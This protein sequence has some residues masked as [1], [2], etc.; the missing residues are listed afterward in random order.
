MSKNNP[1]THARKLLV[2]DCYEHTL[3]VARSLARA[4]YEVILGVTADDLDR[5]YAHLSRSISSTWLHPDIVSDADGFDVVFLK[6]LNQH[7][8][9]KTVFPVGENSVRKLAAIRPSIPHETLIVMPSNDAIDACMN[10]SRAYQLADEC[11]IPVPGTRTVR[12]AEKMLE[13]IDELGMPAIAKP[14]DST[15]LLLN[16]KCVFVRTQSDLRALQENWPGNEHEYVVQNEIAGIRHNCDVVAENGEIKT[17]FEAEVLRTDQ[18]DYA[19]NSVFDRSI[20]PISEHREYCERLISALNYTGLALIQFLRDPETGKTFFLEANPRAGAA[21]ALAVSCGVDLP[22][23]ALRA[24][25]GNSPDVESKYLLYRAR[26]SFHDDLLGIRKA[27][28]YRDIGNWKTL[29]WLCRAVVDATRANYYST[30]VWSDPKPTVKIFW[31]LLV[32]LIFRD[33][34]GLVAKQNEGSQ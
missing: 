31:D 25:A 8:D 19:G 2:L 27:R 30:F 4:G 26:S 22:V 32:R 6:F 33:K 3:T 12:S 18:L 15:N 11:G 34:R 7:P 23:G 13:A 5:G 29:T 1:A 20:P 17:Y 24:C 9:I 14:L 16:K 28:V 21:I 10:K